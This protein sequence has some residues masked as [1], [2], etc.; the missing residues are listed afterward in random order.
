MR[1]LA[2]GKPDDRPD[3]GLSVRG[4]EPGPGKGAL[5]PLLH[6]V[7]RHR[8]VHGAAGEHRR[9]HM[10]HALPLPQAGPGTTWLTWSRACA[11]ISTTR[12]LSAG[13]LLGNF[14]DLATGKRLG[15]LAVGRREAQVPGRLRPGEGRGH[16][17]GASRPRAGSSREATTAKPTS[18][19]GDVRLGPFRRSP[20]PLRDNATKQKIM[21]ILDQRVVMV[22]FIDNANLSASAAKTIGALLQPGDQGPAGDRRSCGR[23]WNAS[24]RTSSEGY[25]RLYD[26]KAGQFYFGRDATKDRHVRLGGPAG[27]MGHG[28]RGLPGQRVPR[29]GHVR[30]HCGSACPWTPSR[31]WASR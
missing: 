27:E 21:D 20:G 10:R 7:D 19:I 5:P 28:P 25:A 24:S 6:P 13:S 29:P 3:L 18:A 1:Y 26:A 15:P 12:E 31:T 4:L 23:S 17:E 11:R 22:V 2:P 8:P 9:R 30:R 16:L 14:L